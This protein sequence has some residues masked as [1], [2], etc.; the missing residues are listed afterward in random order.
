MFQGRERGEIAVGDYTK[1]LQRVQYAIE[2]AEREIY[3]H[4]RTEVDKAMLGAIRELADVVD[5]FIKEKA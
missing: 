2:E 5:H 1:P 3:Y 4:R